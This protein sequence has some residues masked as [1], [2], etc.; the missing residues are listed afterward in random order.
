[1]KTK[2]QV[3]LSRNLQFATAAVDTAGLCLFVAF[4]VL[5]I[6]AAFEAVYEM[7]NAQYGLEL[8]PDDV[9]E[10]GKTVIMT[11]REFNRNA[12]F[13]AEDDRLPMFFETEKLPP[14]NV[15]FDIPHEE[16]DAVFSA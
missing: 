16:L 7:L 9:S 11:E 12:G 6:P 14:H 2:G 8:G 10:L 4:A 15:V 1:L 5:D 3:E 13:T